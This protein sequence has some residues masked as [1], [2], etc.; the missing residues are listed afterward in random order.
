MAFRLPFRNLGV[1]MDKAGKGTTSWKSVGDQVTRDFTEV[2]ERL[3]RLSEIAKVNRGAVAGPI[4]ALNTP[5]NIEYD[6]VLFDPMSRWHLGDPDHLGGYGSDYFYEVG[7]TGLY[8]VSARLNTGSGTAANARFFLEAFVNGVAVSRGDDRLTS[9]AVSGVMSLQLEDDIP[10][11]TDDEVSIYVTQ[12]NG[13]LGSFS[14][15]GGV[16][17]NR[18]SL[19]WVAPHPDL[20]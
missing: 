12:V 18:A 6:T 15:S 16:P 20:V 19:R 8:H 4:A 1:E 5:F 13:A 10:L 2:E 11:Y 7:P 14:A 9:G 3:T 17:I